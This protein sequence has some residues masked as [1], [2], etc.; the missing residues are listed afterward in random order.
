MPRGPFGRIIVSGALLLAVFGLVAWA[1]IDYADPFCWRGYI[2]YDGEYDGSECPLNGWR[3]E[4]VDTTSK[5][6]NGRVPLPAAGPRPRRA[7]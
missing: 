2:A 4:Q 6:T 5:R 3:H 1:C 7:G